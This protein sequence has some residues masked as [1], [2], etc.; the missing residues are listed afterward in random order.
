MPTHICCLQPCSAPPAHPPGSQRCSI[1]LPSSSAL[2]TL[3]FALLAA[4]GPLL[5][6]RIFLAVC[7]CAS[8]CQPRAAASRLLLLLIFTLLLLLPI[9]IVLVAAAAGEVCGKVSL[10]ELVLTHLAAQHLGGGG[11]TATPMVNS[12]QDK[13]L[14]QTGQ[15]RAALLQHG[16]KNRLL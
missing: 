3:L 10:L 5:L 4:L 15:D 16:R 13:H 11:Q 6:L 7:L 9:F 1:V 12:L 8:I 14:L 2:Q